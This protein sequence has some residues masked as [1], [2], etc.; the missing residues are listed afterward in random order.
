MRAVY[1][2]PSGFGL[3][4]RRKTNAGRRG[5]LGRSEHLSMSPD[6]IDPPTGHIVPEGRTPHRL[7]VG[8]VLAVSNRH[9][10]LFRGAVRTAWIAHRWAQTPKGIEESQSLLP[11]RPSPFRIYPDIGG[12]ICPKRHE[13][14]GGRLISS[15]AVASIREA[16]ILSPDAFFDGKTFDFAASCTL[17]Y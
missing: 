12:R 1:T 9:A 7:L 3:I 13:K 15:T 11:L 2:R 14:E 6:L 8:P 4:L 10:R 5:L 16:E 17:N